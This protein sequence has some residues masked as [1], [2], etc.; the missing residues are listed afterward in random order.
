MPKYTITFTARP[1]FT[2]IYLT[3]PFAA[4]KGETDN[5]YLAGRFREKGLAVT[6][7]KASAK[8]AKK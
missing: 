8:S 7:A 2:G 6:D 1:D 4:G 5:S 3:V